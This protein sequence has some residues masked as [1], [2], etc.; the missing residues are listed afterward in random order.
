MTER[1]FLHIGLPKTGTTYLQRALWQNRSV[2]KDAGLLLPAHQ[3]RHL[4]A[5]LDLRDDP[6]LA[7]RT[8]DVRAPW[9]DLVKEARTWPGDVLITHEFFGPA[10]PAQ[11]R[12][13]LESFPGAEV[14]VLITARE[15]VGLAI[16]RWQ[17]YVRN[18]GPRP[19]DRY[20]ADKPYDPTD[21]WGWASFDLADILDRWGSVIAH[22]RVHVLPMTPGA[23]DPT[24]LL[25]RFLAVMGYADAPVE[26]PEQPANESLGLVEAELLRRTTPLMRDFRSA[27]D[28]GNWIR[29]YLAA[30]SVMPSSGERFRP[31][32]ER[33]AELEERGRRA[34]VT[35]RKGG[36]DVVGDIA[37]LEPRPDRD[38]RQPG[39][40]SDREQLDV[41]VQVI[42]TLM[43][44]IRDLTQEQRLASKSAELRRARVS[45]SRFVLGLFSKIRKDDR[46]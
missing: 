13:A 36:Y 28:R 17:E 39:D 38:R 35:L 26:M 19:I 5:T 6:K 10:S 16:S 37:L 46:R 11:A 45:V 18:G 32:D 43:T 24:E 29:G 44:R 25:T 27:A 9:D 8:G 31:S 30:P 42:A 33:L 2:L 21:A 1:V 14:H 15:M 7:R 23:A 4:L 34:L 3:R 12:R 41:A 20:P 22:D 40:V